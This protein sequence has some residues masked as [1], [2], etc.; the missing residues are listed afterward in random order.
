MSPAIHYHG[1]E[2]SGLEAMPPDVRAAYEREQHGHAQHEHPRHQ[3]EPA[4][5]DDSDDDGDEADEADDDGVPGM[6]HV[7]PA[8]GGARLKGT[9]AVP[10]GFGSVTGLGPAVAVHESITWMLP[11]FGPPRPKVAV[12]YRDGLA[13]QAHGKDIHTWRWE[14]IAAVQSSLE[15]QRTAGDGGY[16]TLVEYTLAQPSGEKIILDVRLKQLD[17]LAAAV[18]KAVYALIGP[19]L[20]QQYRAGQALTFGPVTI[21]QQNGLQANGKLHAW[22]AIQDIQV[23]NGQLKLTFGDGKKHNVRVSAV[24]NF[25]L[26]CQ[27]IGLEPDLFAMTYWPGL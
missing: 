10:P 19:P 12:R 17:Q 25:E 23:E 24:P 3:A 15:R 26:L 11:S 22:D 14:E 7:A 2:Y 9:V 20:A 18:K 4:P 13:F 27:L 1:E 16:Y 5:E 8:W 6:P 21:H